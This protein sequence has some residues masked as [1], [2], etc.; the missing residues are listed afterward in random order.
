MSEIVSSKIIVSKFGGSSMADHKSMI[1]SA[2]IVK[3]QNSTI[4]L[5]SATYK[6]TDFLVSLINNAQHGNWNECEKTLFQLREKHFEICNSITKAQD[7]NQVMAEQLRL[8]FNEFGHVL[9]VLAFLH[10][11]NKSSAGMVGLLF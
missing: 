4:V 10:E 9:P 6:T 8:F 5:V 11:Q 2:K 3:E 7:D 1:R